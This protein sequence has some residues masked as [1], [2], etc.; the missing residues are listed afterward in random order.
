MVNKI[1]N[2]LLDKS[3]LYLYDFI[4]DGKHSYLSDVEIDYLMQEIDKKIIE[5]GESYDR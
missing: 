4:I 3:K 5:D 1:K 2:H